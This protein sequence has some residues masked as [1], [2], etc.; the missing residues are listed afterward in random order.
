[1]TS[2]D[3]AWSLTDDALV[4]I[5]HA[6]DVHDS[7]R[8][9]DT[10]STL[11]PGQLGGATERQ[12]WPRETAVLRLIATVEAFAN[13]ASELSFRLKGLPVP[14]EPFTWPA[15]KKHYTLYHGF[16]L[17]SCDGWRP[18][19]AGID[20][21]N[22]LAH[23]LGNLTDLLLKDESLGARM[24]ELDVVVS[25][26]RM[27]FARSTVPTLVIACRKFVR[28]LEQQLVAQL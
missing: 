7:L 24:K 25:G 20:L 8:A 9:P 17:E 15:R 21:R 27:H 6:G 26:N 28:S 5:L 10:F 14:K 2:D 16:S 18:V 3:P 19:E 13:A 23:G 1:M 11:R 4:L 22:C 12:A